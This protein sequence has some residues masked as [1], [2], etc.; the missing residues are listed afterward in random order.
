MGS[1]NVVEERLDRAMVTSSWWDLF[2]ETRLDNLIAPVSDHS[3]I[4]LSTIRRPHQ[5][6]HKHF[7]FENY[8]LN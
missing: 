4:F 1:E 8:W 7:K 3:P 6:F 5:A 2:P